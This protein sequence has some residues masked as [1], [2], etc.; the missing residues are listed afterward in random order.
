M[1]WPHAALPKARSAFVAA[2]PFVYLLCVYK[3]VKTMT[4]PHDSVGKS[5][6]KN[7]AGSRPICFDDVAGQDAAVAELRELVTFLHDRAAY[8]AMGARLPRGV[9]LSGPAGTGKTLLARALAS[10]ASCSFIFVSASEFVE[11]LVGRGAA[12]VRDLF[13]RARAKAPAIVFIDEIDALAK[14]RGGLHSNDEREQTL[15]QVPLQ[16]AATPESRH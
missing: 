8:D 14:A 15:N 6:R 11:T 16:P 13:K 10:E 7:I 4:N 12:R 1:P 9:L 3:L 2:V 5:V